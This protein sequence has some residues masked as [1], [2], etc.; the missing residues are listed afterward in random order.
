MKIHYEKDFIYILKRLEDDSVAQAIRNLQNVQNQDL[1]INWVSLSDK[2]GIVNFKSDLKITEKIVNSFGIFNNDEEK[3]NVIKRL[4][5][6]KNVKEDV[7]PVEIKLGRLAQRLLTLTGYSFSNRDIETFVNRFVAHVKIVKGI[8]FTIFKGD[9]ILKAYNGKN[10]STMCGKSNPLHTSCMTNQHKGFFKIYTKNPEVCSLLVIESDGKIFGRGFLWN[11]ELKGKPIKILDRVYT[12]KE[13]DELLFR[14]WAKKNDYVCRKYN[15]NNEDSNAYRFVEPSGKDID[16]KGVVVRLT[17]CR[18]IDYPYLDTF[19]FLNR[20]NGVVSNDYKIHGKEPCI[21]IRSTGGGFGN[22]G[23]VDGLSVVVT[24]NNEEVFEE[25]CVYSRFHRKHLMKNDATPVH[26]SRKDEN[27]SDYISLKHGKLVDN[28]F[29]NTIVYS[30]IDNKYY[31]KVYS[32]WSKYH[33][34]YISGEDC[35]LSELG[36][37]VLKSYKKQYLEEYKDRLSNIEVKTEKKKKTK[38]LKHGSDISSLNFDTFAVY[39]KY[40]DLKIRGLI[41]KDRFYNWYLFSNEFNGSVGDIKSQD[42][43]YR[44]S[45]VLN[46]ELDRNKLVYLPHNDYDV[47]K[48]YVEY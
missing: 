40:K 47:D 38:I 42:L 30:V 8:N 29:E 7:T 3:E 45:W 20:R 46:S 19:K 18:F 34:S 13:C 23:D 5:N 43:G 48:F 41:A 27:T 14:Q 6:R 21:D 24:I 39:W 33:N 25:L 44:Y 31:H 11:A 36:D 1:D 35:W 32:Q 10:Y 15:N 17:D 16:I 9:D 2:D 12:V 22:I 26:N 28:I 4:C 37:Y